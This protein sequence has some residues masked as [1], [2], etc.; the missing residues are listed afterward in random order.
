MNATD[1]Y[2]RIEK[3][4]GLKDEV[5]HRVELAL[6]TVSLVQDWGAVKALVGTD[7]DDGKKAMDVIKLVLLEKEL[8]GNDL[9]NKFETILKT[10]REELDA[11][12]FETLKESILKRL[13][14]KENEI[15]RGDFIVTIIPYLKENMH[16]LVNG[17]TIIYKVSKTLEKIVAGA[18]AERVA[19][20][21]AE[22][23]A[24]R[25]AEAA[26]AAAAD[27]AAAEADAAAAETKA[28][29][30]AYWSA[31]QEQWQTYRDLPKSAPSNSQIPSPPPTVTHIEEKDVAAGG[32]DMDSLLST[33][34]FA[35]G[36]DNDMM[37]TASFAGGGDN[38]MMSTAYT[39]SHYD[40]QDMMD[41]SQ[42]DLDALLEKHR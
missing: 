31:S 6:P 8:E 39:A 19:E 40:P 20:A 4:P 26:D 28:A 32:E 14:I 38:D 16:K 30:K 41:V 36:G 25:V 22:A 11:G 42:L 23:E 37:S 17:T 12:R 13:E 18:E 10:T 15:D 21:K 24:E 27:A 2:K 3:V 5:I 29:P 7:S 35:A 1:I 34:S 33:A 9:I